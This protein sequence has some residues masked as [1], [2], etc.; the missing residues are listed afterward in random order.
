M[1]QDDGTPAGG[2]GNPAGPPHPGTER[3][4]KDPG[5][6]PGATRTTPADLLLG[7]IAVE[8]GLVGMAALEEALREQEAARAA[9][10]ERSLGQ[11]LLDRGRIAAGDL[12]RLRAE[13]ERRTRAFP[14]I[15]RYRIQERLGEGATAVVYRAWD[16]EV[17]RPVAL[18]VLR[19]AACL[20][21]VARQRFRREAQAAGGLNHPNVTT[22]Y[23]AGEA[24]GLLYLALELVEGRSLAD[25]LR[26]G[27]TGERE[28]LG[29][30]EKASRGVAAAHARGVVHRDLKPANILVTA[31]G[32][33]K[34]G[35]F[36]L[37]H[38]ADSSVELTKTG[39]TLG[40][41]LYMSPEQVQG[42]AR[43]AT[44]ATDVYALGA[45]LYEIVAGRPPHAGDT[46]LEIYARILRDEP[47]PPRRLNPRVP[48]DLETIILKALEKEPSRRYP[49]A[50]AF[51]DD[52]RRYLEGKPI[53][54]RPPT[55]L[56]RIWRR[57]LRHR[58]ALAAAAAA[59]ALGG[60]WIAASRGRRAEQEALRLL[61][62]ARPAL[63]NAFH[64]LY[65]R[66]AEYGELLRRVEKARIPIEEALAR[67]PHLA[68]GHY[69]LG[70]VRELRG[71]EDGAEA[72][73]R[74]ALEIDGGLTPARFQLG[75][76]LLGRACRAAIGTSAEERESRRPEA[77]RLAGEAAEQIERAVAAGAGFEEEV[78]REVARAMLAY[79][80]RDPGG[81]LR[82]AGEAAERYGRTKGAEELHWLLGLAGGGEDPIRCFDRALD[83]RPRHPLVLLCRAAARLER[84][85]PAGA[86]RDC[87]EALKIHP[88]FADAFYNRGVARYRQ[89]DLEGAARD[90]T[91]V[92]GLVPGHVHALTNRGI[93][94]SDQGRLEEA[95][96]DFDRALALEPRGTPARYNRGVARI[97][98][99][100]LDEAL[101]DFE[102]TLR[103]DPRHAGAFA[104]R[105]FVRA[106]KGDTEGA[107]EDYGRAL[108][109]DPAHP[110]ARNNR[111]NVLR[112]MGRLEEAIADF[113]EALRADPR[114]AE[115]YYNRGLAR[116]EGGNVAGA[117]ED[118][119]RAIGIRP[120]WAAP[121]LVRAHI[122]LA[123]GDL[124]GAETDARKALELG[125]EGE[126]R[127]EMNRIL[128]QQDED[129]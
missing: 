6:D 122:R 126:D 84:G 21:E 121:R 65:D 9:G 115:A 49:D 25:L 129:F 60:G 79:A 48:R 118:L 72:C 90:F 18:K 99:G 59:A 10:R 85:D 29:I 71:D 22:I 28:L 77:G 117:L 31:A 3:L 44:P 39:C 97:R 38:L 83:L 113:D 30:L 68:A 91:A 16:C 62:T 32:E 58:A 108:A 17:G 24:G 87:E 75:R 4:L 46:T 2:K 81:V 111:G 89:G 128:G 45:I 26:Q 20:S 103:I 47:V 127:R 64:Y 109:I 123:E 95:M 107:L 41:P 27:R 78:H 7:R 69:L 80:T 51:A 70:R 104:M 40:T 50:A 96:S 101:G 57:A 52:L 37:A 55:R 42:R 66:E 82:I 114:F 36:G 19:E 54:A 88:G 94:R 53:S 43:D 86:A 124:H 102:E 1:A 56:G 76:V 100:R 112:K 73:F 120:A 34:V 106:K 8:W 63:E 110:Q 116:V 12:D 23:D 35:D 119:G 125:V 15:P 33:P 92:L 11:I 93:V 61:E 98:A 105:G 67:A 13:Q 74:R 14:E 5:P